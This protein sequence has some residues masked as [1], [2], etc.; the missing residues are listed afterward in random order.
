MSCVKDFCFSVIILSSVHTMLPIQYQ[1]ANNNWKRNGNTAKVT[2]IFMC[3]PKNN[4]V[5][6]DCGY[7]T[8][9]TDLES[10]IG[11]LAT[12]YCV[13][14]AD[15]RNLSTNLLRPVASFK[16]MPVYGE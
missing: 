6:F 12:T 9:L 1:H 15:C 13:L 16:F 7:S 10:S 3:F 5:S 4:E 2:Y 14:Q 8:R 11:Q